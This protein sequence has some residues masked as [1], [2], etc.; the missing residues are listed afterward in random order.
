MG[1]RYTVRSEQPYYLTCTVV[2]WVDVFTRP[3]YRHI[4]V[5]A[6]RYCQQQKGL[7]LFAWCLMSNHLHLLARAADGHNLAHILRDF[8]KFTSKAIVQ[9][10]LDEPTESRQA[11]LLDRFYFYGI[12]NPKITNAKFWQ[13]G[14]HAVEVLTPAFAQQKLHYIHQNP[15][16]AQLVLEAEAYVFSSASNYAGGRGLLEVLFLD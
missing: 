13:D 7:E 1:I 10:I 5:D 9:A 14:S 16:R 12:V 8:K 11:W 3:V 2:D 15:V 4:I 6:L